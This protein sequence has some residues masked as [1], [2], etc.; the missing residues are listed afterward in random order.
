[1]VM[2]RCRD[3]A[4]ECGGLDNPGQKKK[5]RPTHCDNIVR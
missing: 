1:M 3:E 4:M 5:E 2:Q